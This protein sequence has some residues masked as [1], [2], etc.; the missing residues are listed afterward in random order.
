MRL[1]PVPVLLSLALL[2]ALVAPARARADGPEWMRSLKEAFA[3]ARERGAPILVWCVGDEDA[4]E[5]ADHKV[6]MDARVQRAMAGYLVVL[7]NPVDQ[8]GVVDGKLD[9]KPARMC[10]LVPE[11]QCSHHKAMF[12][13]CYGTF[14]DFM[15]DKTRA[16]RFPNHFVV[17]ADGKL[18]G[19]INA[20]NLMSGF[21]VAAASSFEKELPKILEKSGG[22]GLTDEEFEDYRKR[23]ESARVSA[24]QGRLSEAAATLVPIS[25][26]RKKIEIVAQAKEI[27]ARVDK[28]AS[29]LLGAGRAALKAGKAL[30]GLATLERVS[31]EYPGTDSAKA[32]AK[33]AEEFRG[34]PAG[35]RVL[36]DLKR[37][38]KGREAL[39]KALEAADAGDRD[40]EALRMLDGVA[41]TWAGL[42]SGEEA[43]QRAAAIRA[44]PERGAAVRAA[45]AE[46]QASG[47]L[48]LAKGFLEGGKREEARLRLEKVVADFPD[49][50]AAAEAKRLLEGL[51]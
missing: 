18:L 35:K 46:K 32:A 47:D 21:G 50:A 51:R 19:S 17:D 45:L 1:R 23:L 8:H 49:T 15:L 24:D 48:L 40:V 31:T 9:G 16:A 41:K 6:L 34:S 4:D 38:Q 10:R 30:E 33:E 44:D 12:N 42:P 5:Q 26:L 29:E 14:P 28:K 2:V 11:I 3:R 20:G 25:A 22:P 43:A 36:A 7:A 13:E 37:E 39:L 27:L